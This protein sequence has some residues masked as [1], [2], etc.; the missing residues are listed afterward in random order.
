MSTTT[1]IKTFK[2]NYLTEAQYNAAK[3]NDQI[4]PNELYVTPSGISSGVS[5]IGE[6]RQFA[7]STAPVNWLICD[8]SAVSRDTYSEL[9]AVIGTTYGSGNGSTTFNIPDLRGRFPIGSNT[10][11]PIGTTGGESE[12]TLSS[13]ELPNIQGQARMA[14]G[15]SSSAGVMVTAAS[16]VFSAT[17]SGTAYYTGSSASGS[18]NNILKM[19]FGSDQ[20]HNNMPPY[21]G[22]NYI[23]CYRADNS[24]TSVDYIVDQ[25]TS[26][27]WT[28][29]K[30][31][32]GIAECWGRT[33]IV[34]PSSGVYSTPFPFTF[35]SIT[36][37]SV[38]PF[39][40]YQTDAARNA[41]KYIVTDGNNNGSGTLG[42]AIVYVRDYAGNVVNPSIAFDFRVSGTWK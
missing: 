34:T 22:V 32:S 30:W 40:G 33:A 1:D 39:Y 19:S 11:Y 23:I 12:H 8:G 14:W 41:T 20:P 18:Y 5:N 31:N 9:F 42:D 16:G 35:V 3:D 10:T 15:D 38:N 36:C 26:G 2:I 29:R 4:E 27:I 24:T 28:Y 21:L 7:G 6:I 25:G 37:N 13:G 17:S